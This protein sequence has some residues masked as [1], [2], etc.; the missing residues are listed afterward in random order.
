MYSIFWHHLL[1]LLHCRYTFRTKKNPIKLDDHDLLFSFKINMT[2]RYLKT[3]ITMIRSS[4]CLHYLLRLKN[5]LLKSEWLIGLWH[6]LEKIYINLSLIMLKCPNWI[7]GIFQMNCWK[8]CENNN[9]FWSQIRVKPFDCQSIFGVI[10]LCEISR[11]GSVIIFMLPTN[12][13]Q[14]IVSI[15]NCLFI[16]LITVNKVGKH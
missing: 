8:I 4:E 11:S 9:V 6:N 13:P 12:K 10:F 5:T 16:Y 7:V 2:R 14:R 1:R 3:L 15:F